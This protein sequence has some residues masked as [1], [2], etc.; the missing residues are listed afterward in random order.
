M[1]MITLLPKELVE[2]DFERVRSPSIF[3]VLKFIK[4]EIG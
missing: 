1:K 4:R 3:E 2:V